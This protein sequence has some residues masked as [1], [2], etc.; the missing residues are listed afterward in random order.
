[1]PVV[2]LVP[3]GVSAPPADVWGGG[4]GTMAVALPNGQ[5]I[6]SLHLSPKGPLTTGDL[7]PSAAQQAL[8]LQSAGTTTVTATDPEG[9]KFE[10]V[11]VVHC[12]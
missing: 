7:V 5:R 6:L 9:E 11:V 8:L 1:V 4:S 3:S 12:P 10:R 2:Q